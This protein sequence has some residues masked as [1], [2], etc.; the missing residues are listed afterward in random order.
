MTVAQG[1]LDNCKR[2]FCAKFKDKT[3]NNWENRATFV[4]AANKVQPAVW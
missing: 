2:G 4:K 1:T 3:K